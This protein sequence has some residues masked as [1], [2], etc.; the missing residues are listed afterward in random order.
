MTVAAIQYGLPRSGQP[1]SS[2]RYLLGP[3]VARLAKVAF[4]YFFF[5]CGSSNGGVVEASY[6][7]TVLWTTMCSVQHR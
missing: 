6:T 2:W 4:K 3:T 7:S 1:A 5:D